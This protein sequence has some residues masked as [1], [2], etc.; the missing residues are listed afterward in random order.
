MSHDPDH[1][2]RLV[3]IGVSGDSEW[4]LASR[5]MDALEAA[6]V[7]AGAPRLLEAFDAALGSGVLAVTESAK[8]SARVSLTGPLGSQ[9][10][11]LQGLVSKAVQ[12]APVCVLASGDPGFFGLLRSLRPVMGEADI[13]VHPAP[14]SVSLAFARLGMAWDRAA[15][16]SAHGRDADQAALAA[17]QALSDPECGLVAILCSPENHPAKMAAMLMELSGLPAETPEAACC[18]RLASQD[19]A[20]FRS[21]LQHIAEQ[22]NLDPLC[23]LVISAK[24]MAGVS[25]GKPTLAWPPTR[26]ALATVGEWALWEEDFAHRGD[27]IT[28]AEVQAWILPRLALPHDGVFWDLG[29]GSGSV[30]VEVARLRPAMRVIAVERDPAQAERIAANASVHEVEVEIVLGEAPS[31]LESLPRPD[32]CFVGGGG[33]GVLEAALG[34]VLPGGRVVSAYASLERAAAAA[35]RLGSLVQISASRGSRLADGSWRLAAS[36][37]VFVAWGPR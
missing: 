21:S 3:L 29:A 24:P 8:A 17:A 4:N 14:S 23:V 31:V 1:K 35:E 9:L 26:A 32:R 25:P 18:Q 22:D 19:E 2:P 34:V 6:G 28:K 16:V 33:I 36:N 5:A 10:G 30:A 27:C 7:V 11:L 12:G 15:V 37:P 13:E 20:I